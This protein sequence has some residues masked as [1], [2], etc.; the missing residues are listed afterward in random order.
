MI[1][2]RTLRWRLV[3]LFVLLALLSTSVF[4]Q[5]SERLMNR[6]FQTLVVP[7]LS[8]YVGRLSNELGTPPDV[9]KA[10]AL[11]ER[12]PIQ[13]HINGPQVQWSS[14]PDWAEH[15][16]QRYNE[17]EPE[18]RRRRALQ[19]LITRHTADGHT[20][21]FGVDRDRWERDNPWHVWRPIFLLV[22]VTLLCYLIIHWLF[23]PLQDI[24]AGAQRFGRGD[25]SQPIPESRS[26]E[27]GTLAKDVNTMAHNLDGMLQAQRSMLLAISHELRSPLT[28]ARLQAELLPE[29]PE[30]T[31]L[32][33]ELTAMNNMIHE[34]LHSERMSTDRAALQLHDLNA[35][36]R[37]TVS[38]ISQE[39]NWT[40]ELLANIKWSLAENL[41]PVLLDMSRFTMLLRNLLQNA[42]RY[43]AAN[44]HGLTLSTQLGGNNVI[45]CLRDWGSGID[46]T[47]LKSLG[48]P[49]YRPDEARSRSQGGV[50]LGLYVCRRIAQSMQIALRF[51]NVNPGLQ[52]CLQW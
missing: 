49:F 5:G 39:E 45:L 41:P 27:W 8:D 29:S 25:F 9:R 11:V 7:L 52:V 50:G 46:P 3:A 4:K 38:I 44:E 32:I 13:I 28:R 37:Q 14:D 31:H 47:H 42:R 26:D 6:S 15:R 18:S 34:L 19:A 51:E 43:G 17:S 22:I 36:V 21:F 12:L 2:W 35:A 30:Q 20:I 23:H 24:R 48:E 40:P 1:W 10:K 16:L 33:R